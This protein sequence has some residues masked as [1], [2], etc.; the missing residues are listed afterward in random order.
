MFVYF[1]DEE[2]KK[3]VYAMGEI[4]HLSH[5]RVILAI[6]TT[7]IKVEWIK[8]LNSVTIDLADEGE[9][10]AVKVVDVTPRFMASDKFDGNYILD[11]ILEYDI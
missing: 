2:S 6:H 10:E 7:S 8:S 4:V 11:F 9:R 5:K 3:E 1:K